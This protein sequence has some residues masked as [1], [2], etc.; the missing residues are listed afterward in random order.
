MTYPNMTSDYYVSFTMFSAR[1]DFIGPYSWRRILNLCTVRWANG[2]WEL[3]RIQGA[4]FSYLKCLFYSTIRNPLLILTECPWSLSLLEEIL[5]RMGV[6]RWP[7]ILWKSRVRYPRL[8]CFFCAFTL[9]RS[10]FAL[11]VGPLATIPVIAG[12]SCLITD[13]LTWK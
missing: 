8:F 2:L 13:Y 12:H 10:C 6:R 3:S 5:C 4:A 7:E 9:P 11:S 1:F